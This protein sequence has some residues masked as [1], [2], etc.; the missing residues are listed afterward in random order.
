VPA[1]RESIAF[2]VDVSRIGDP[3]NGCGKDFSVEYRCHSRKRSEQ[4]LRKAAFFACQSALS[5]YFACFA[6][7]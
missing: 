2:P 7:N 1:I 6:G 3:A 5:P 4:T